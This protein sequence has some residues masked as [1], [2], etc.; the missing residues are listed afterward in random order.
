M[1]SIKPTQNP[2]LHAGGECHRETVHRVP[3][4][5][6]THALINVTLLPISRRQRAQAAEKAHVA[7]RRHPDGITTGLVLP[8]SVRVSVPQ[9]CLTDPLPHGTL[10]ASAGH[11]EYRPTGTVRRGRSEI[12]PLPGS[13]G[14]QKK[15]WSGNWRSG[16]VVLHG[17]I[18]VVPL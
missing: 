11:C 4:L 15:A 17:N 8:F 10:R 18:G 14:T 9:Q 3:K 7:R 1:K 2:R 12:T 6:R 5:A 16:E 13:A